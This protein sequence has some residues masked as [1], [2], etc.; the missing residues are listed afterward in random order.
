MEDSQESPRKPSLS[1]RAC[2]RCYK[3]KIRCNRELP[4]CSSCSIQ[5]QDCAYGELVSPPPTDEARLQPAI[6]PVGL[7][8][9]GRRNHSVTLRF[10]DSEVC[11]RTHFDVTGHA[12]SAPYYTAE[13]LE[14]TRVNQSIAAQ[15]FKL[16][17]PWFPIIS[18][19]RFY[20]QLLN[21][22]L[23]PRLD[24]SFL[25][26]CMSMISRSFADGEDDARTTEYRTALRLFLE[27][28]LAGILSLEVLQACLLI[29]AY[30]F[31]HAIY[32]AAQISVGICVKYA[33]ALGI[34]W[35]RLAPPSSTPNWAE[36]EE[37]RRVCWGVY[38]IERI[39]NVGDP[40]QPLIF[41]EPGTSALLPLRDWEWD[42]ELTLTEKGDAPKPPCLSSPHTG[43]GRFAGVAQSVY[44]LGQVYRH[45]ADKQM[46]PEF[47]R[48]EVLQLDRTIHGLL[49]YLETNRGTNS[50]VIC[51]Q[52]TICFN[53]LVLL[54]SP[55]AKAE[56][57]DENLTQLRIN[58]F[59]VLDDSASMAFD[60]AKNLFLHFELYDYKFGDIPP[61]VLPFMY[62]SGVRYIELFKKDGSEEWRVRLNTLKRALK[63]IDEKW[64]SAGVSP[65][66]FCLYEMTY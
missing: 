6:A 60:M 51:Y 26:V 22:L 53:A 32:P 25:C 1:R 3:R 39:S 38:L 31:A 24:V 27:V 8:H 20:N 36:D 28:Q 57:L 29:A 42:S 58:S 45:L 63:H 12:L 43:L 44:L 64:K 19:K 5:K 18:Q 17:H 35:E 50:S 62:M 33:L 34:D 55:Y 65:K 15:Y 54:Y 59:D 21:P 10:L 2:R 37:K 41:P 11:K 56:T 16:H 47:R 9:T 14:S 7:Y 61:F 23:P 49:R 46:S 52:T 66:L 13:S 4:Q 40:Q 30:E 48:A